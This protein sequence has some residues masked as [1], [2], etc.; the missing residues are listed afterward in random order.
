ML[1]G[2]PVRVSQSMA[3]A[4]KGILLNGELFLSP[5]MYSLAKDTTPEELEHLFRNLPI[6]NL[7]DFNPFDVPL[8]QAISQ[9]VLPSSFS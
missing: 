7:G 4:K 2:I 9:A 8:T 3:R 5:A 1:E 6:L